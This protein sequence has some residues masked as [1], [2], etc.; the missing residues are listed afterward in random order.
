MSLSIGVSFSTLKASSLVP[1][2]SASVWFTAELDLTTLNGIPCTVDVRTGKFPAEAETHCGHWRLFKAWFTN[3]FGTG[4]MFKDKKVRVLGPIVLRLPPALGP[5]RIRSLSPLHS[6]PHSAP[7]LPLYAPPS[8]RPSHMC[9]TTPSTNQP[10][11]S[12]VRRA[13]RLL[14]T[15]FLP[16]LPSPPPLPKFRAAAFKQAVKGEAEME[17]MKEQHEE[18]QDIDA[19]VEGMDSASAMA[20]HPKRQPFYRWGRVWN[21]QFYE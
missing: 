20:F 15:R 18:N 5:K 7:P 9:S 17:A 19:L 10:A 8:A 2:F 1:S 3:F 12:F 13:V 11:S 4:G 16:P 14:L 6:L 21:A